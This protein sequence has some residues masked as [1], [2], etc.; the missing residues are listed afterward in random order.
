MSYSDILKAGRS[1]RVP[2]IE[3]EAASDRH[4]RRFDVSLRDMAT[5]MEWAKC[6]GFHVYVHN[7]GQHWQIERAGFIAEWWPA[8]AKLVIGKDWEHGIHC[9]DVGQVI[10]EIQKGL[11]IV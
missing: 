6:S 2:F 5:F 3:G 9:H 7:K 4:A 11:G 10:A 8:S 1:E